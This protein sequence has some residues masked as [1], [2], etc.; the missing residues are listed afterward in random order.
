MSS[1]QNKIT[2]VL[3]LDL[4]EQLISFTEHYKHWGTNPAAPSRTGEGLV[5]RK[6]VSWEFP[7]RKV[8]MYHHTLSQQRDIVPWQE[9]NSSEEPIGSWFKM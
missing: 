3:C 9:H 2:G 7:L 5:P 1:Q 6:Q 4:L 8:G